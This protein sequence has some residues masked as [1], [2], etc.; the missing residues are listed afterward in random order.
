MARLL[1]LTCLA[2]AVV[3]LAGLAVSATIRAARDTQALGRD[4]VVKTG[5]SNVQKIAYVA[6]IVL[7]LGVTS[8]LLGGL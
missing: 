8:G 1:M 3:A 6:L 5:G 4:L 7:M 2:L